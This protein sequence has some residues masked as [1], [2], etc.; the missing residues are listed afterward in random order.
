MIAQTALPPHASSS[1]V[2]VVQP[3]AAGWAWVA[4]CGAIHQALAAGDLRLPVGRDEALR[5][6]MAGERVACFA[7]DAPP[8]AGRFLALGHVQA[9]GMVVDR[10]A[11]GR[12]WAC[13]RVAYLPTRTAPLAAVLDGALAA[14]GWG[15]SLP[16]G[17]MRL[18]GARLD[19]IACALAVFTGIA[20]PPGRI[21]SLD[22]VD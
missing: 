12:E 16:V 1:P 13:R 6:V 21:A 3:G 22:D 11:A 17:L 20:F 5:L 7:P 15:T 18:D 19:A 9:G 14:M 4:S 8:G 10:D 2:P